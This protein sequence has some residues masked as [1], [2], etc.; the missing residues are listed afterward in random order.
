LNLERR[1]VG[2]PRIRLRPSKI[3]RGCW[4]GATTSPPAPRPGPG[5]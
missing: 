3:G 5:V 1:V 4:S 2:I